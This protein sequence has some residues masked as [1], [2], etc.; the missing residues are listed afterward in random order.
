[1]AHAGDRVD[2][3]YQGGKGNHAAVQAAV[4]D[5]MMFSLRWNHAWS[6][7]SATLLRDFQE[8]DVGC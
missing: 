2:H 3:G 8:A 6:A 1:M 5:A 7:V 4:R